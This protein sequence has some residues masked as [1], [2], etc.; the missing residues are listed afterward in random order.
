[1]VIKKQWYEIV[2]PK[3]FNE[4]IIGE[5]LAADAKQLIG[6]R[7]KVSLLE[8]SRDCPKFYLTLY[9]QVDSVEG[10]KAYTKLVGSDCMRERIYRMVQRRL[11]RV[12]CIQDVKTTDGQN[13]R[14]KTLFVLIRRAGSSLKS[15][16]RKK[17]KEVIDKIAK[18]KTFEE[19][20]KMIIADEIQQAVRKECNKI[21]P[22]GNVEIRKSEVLVA[23][24]AK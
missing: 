20:I 3:S 17:C 1:M 24:E 2:A 7:I 18:E 23:K 8:I 12:D 15:E 21:S 16:A 6:R 22:V 14:I 5:T 19:L 13:V 9:F 11:C 4:K 10:T